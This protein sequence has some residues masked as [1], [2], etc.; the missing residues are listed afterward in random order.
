MANRVKLR[1][2]GLTYSQTQTGSY[3]LVLA[4]D[5]GKKRI[6]I[7]IGA[8]EAQAIALH[9][10]ELQPPRPLTH[11]LFRSFSMAFGVELLEVFINKLEEGIFYSEL[12]FSNEKEEVRIDSRTSDAVALALRFKCPIFTTQEII[13]KAGIILEDKVAE[14]EEDFIGTEVEDETLE[15][16]TLEELDALLYEAVANEDY[17]TASEIRDE[18]KRREGKE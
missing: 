16:R 11:D 1:V 15:D 17:E 6:P 2:M 5:A 9:L 10:E 18:M 4:E 3:A 8:F 13:D 12:L 7:M 14:K